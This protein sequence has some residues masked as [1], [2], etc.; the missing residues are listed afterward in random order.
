MSIAN[1]NGHHDRPRD[2]AFE[3]AFTI[4]AASGTGVN[5]TPLID[6][7]EH[8]APPDPIRDFLL[9]DWSVEGLEEGADWR[10]Y[11][12]WLALLID[13]C[14]PGVDPCARAARHAALRCLRA[15]VVAF[16]EQRIAQR[17]LHDLLPD[18]G[19]SSA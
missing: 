6:L 13:R 5:P 7:A 8:R 17:L 9:R 19:G 16:D 15:I 4:S 11:V 10:N 3:R 1:G 12:C 14:H 18:I 2:L